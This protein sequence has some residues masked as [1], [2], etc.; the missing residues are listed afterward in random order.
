MKNNVLRAKYMDIKNRHGN[1]H[2]QRI[3]KA[4]A[5]VDD[6]NKIRDI[7]YNHNKLVHKAS[8]GPYNPMSKYK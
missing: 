4:I 6:I 3:S 7:L 5:N 2:A 8:E 1:E